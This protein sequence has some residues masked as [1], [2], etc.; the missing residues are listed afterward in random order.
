MQQQAESKQPIQCLQLILELHKVCQFQTNE[1]T[2][3][4]KASNSEIRRWFQAKCIEINFEYPAWNDMMP[5]VLKSI[6][7]FPKNPRKR[8]T[9]YYDDSFTLIQVKEDHGNS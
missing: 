8:C 7:L 9:L 3:V 5:T 6:I 2:K 4:G 1:G